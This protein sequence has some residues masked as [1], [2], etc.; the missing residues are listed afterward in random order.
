[1]RCTCWL[2]L[3]GTVASFVALCHARDDT[4]MLT[5]RDTCSIAAP[6]AFNPTCGPYAD[7]CG[8]HSDD[9][10]CGANNPCYCCDNNCDGDCADGCDGN[11]VWWAWDRACCLWGVGLEWGTN[12][13]TWAYQADLRDYRVSTI[14]AVG[15]IADGISLG[16]VA[17]VTWVSSDKTTVVVSEMG[18]KSACGTCSNPDDPTESVRYHAYSASTFEYIYPLTI[19]DHSFYS[20]PAAPGDE[21]TFVYRIANPSNRAMDSIRL[22]ARIRKSNPQGSWIDDP[23]NDVVIEVASGEADYS[24][25]FRIPDSLEAGYY[26]VGWVIVN[27]RTGEFQTSEAWVDEW[28]DAETL[29]VSSAAEPMIT[30]SLRLDEDSPYYHGDRVTARFTI[31]NEGSAAITF[32]VVTTGGRDPGDEVADFTF[33][34]DITLGP[35]DSYD[36]VGSLDLAKTGVYHFFCAYRLPDGTWNTSVPTL[37]GVTNTLDITVLAPPDPTLCRDPSSLDFGTT[38]TSK[39]FEVWNCGGGTLSYSIS[40]NQAWISV[41]PTS[42]SSTGEQDPITVTVDRSGLSPGHYLGTV[43]IDPNYGSNQTLSVEMDVQATGEP[44]LVYEN[45]VVDDDP[46][47]GSN[48]GNGLIE[49]GEE[50]RLWITVRNI[51]DATA[52]SVEGFLASYSE[53]VITV[54]GGFN[55]VKDYPDVAPGATEQCEYPYRVEI[56]AA[57]P[58]GPASLTLAMVYDEGRDEGPVEI[59]IHPDTTPP[60]PDPMTWSVPPHATAADTIQMTASTAQDIAGVEYY[61]EETSGNTGGSGSGWQDSPQYTDDGLQ[62][63]MWYCYT[64][65]ARDK[66]PNQN[67]TA[68]SPSTFASTPLATGSGTSVCSFGENH[69]IGPGQLGLGDDVDRHS[70]VRI[71]TLSGAVAVAAGASHSLVLLE[72]GDVY[73]FGTN[74]WAELGL[75]DL[76]DRWTPTKIP[77]LSDAKAISAGYDHNLV[78]LANG[79]VYSFGA[80]NAGQ[81]GHNSSHPCSTPTKIPLPSSA[82]AMAAG[83]WHSLI[84]LTN[85]DVYSF[86]WNSHGALGRSGGGYV[87]VKVPGLSNVVAVSAGDQHSLALTQE[88][89]VYVF[90]RNDEG[91]LGLGDT[92]DRDEPAKLAGLSNVVA[93]EAGYYYSL[94]LLQTREV[95][96]FGRNTEGQLGHGDT[97]NRDAPVRISAVS[98][99]AEL[100]AGGHT[101]VALSNGDVFSFGG[102]PYGQLGHGDTDE[103]HSPSQIATLH[104]ALGLAAGVAH[105]LV[106][107]EIVSTDTAAVFRISAEGDVFS[108][109]TVRASSFATDSADVAEW[110]TVTGAVEAGDVVALDPAAPQEYCLTSCACSTLVAGVISSQ[111]GVALGE[112]SG[113][114]AQALLALVG[115]VPVKVT[116]EGGSIMPGDLL[117]SSSTPGHAMRWSGTDPCSCSLV[118]KALEPMG[119]ERGVIL[120]LLTAH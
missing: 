53:D 108:D 106:L 21:L 36:Y 10:F 115:I 41:S 85:G 27:E 33:R 14:P 39:T 104:E 1:M 119:N 30:A 82:L 46:V 13:G 81:L 68:P 8:N 90:G 79:D 52:H 28:V 110:V 56:S 118:G 35:S 111:P 12:G 75:G 77:T 19:V 112:G 60:G 17:W 26:D 29:A 9:C 107:G 117:V 89:D 78:L 45:H 18:C 50:I 51:G 87:P 103:R 95:Y 22:G 40:D 15:T 74:N 69:E 65:R 67:V 120:V 76:E 80:N 38:S 109:S 63:G 88:G 93:I 116:N 7:P 113:S 16:H 105:S 32:D 59:E 48:N 70:P 97:V 54:N 92:L 43:T 66:S 83:A 57:C 58:V 86:G 42:G 94:V 11:C 84:V 4:L 114:G 49:P 37:P 44:E 71:G 61:F 100:A 62:D 34:N 24:R 20:S 23:G 5:G 101:L 31:S 47:Y 64:V 102:N 91:Q 3:I 96:S 73:A 25:A 2:L 72:N 55:D 6:E 98:D 99:V